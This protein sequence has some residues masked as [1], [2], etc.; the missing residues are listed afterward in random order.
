MFYAAGAIIMSYVIPRVESRFM[1]QFMTTISVPSAVAYYSSVATGMLAL[2]GVIFSLLFVMV[3]FSATAYSPR[4]VLWIASDRSISH[5][6][7]V[8][9][10][11]FIF[12]LAALVWVDRDHSGTVGQLSAACVVLLL[13]ASIAVLGYLVQR[14][15][16]LRISNILRLV[17][18][19]GRKEIMDL[20]PRLTEESSKAGDAAQPPPASAQQP[21]VTQTISYSGNPRAVETIDAQRLISL[22]RRAQAVIEVM[23]AVGDM[24]FDGMP[25]LNVRG[26]GK[27]ISERRLRKSIHLHTERTFAQDP[28]YVLRILVDIAIRAL[29]P[30]VN[31]PTTAV[32]ALDQIE[33][34]LHLLARRDLDIGRGRDKDDVLRLTMPVPSWDD[35]LSLACDEILIYGSTSPQVVRRMRAMLRELMEAV[36]PGRRPAVERQIAALDR[37]IDR[38]FADDDHR[39][40]ARKEDRQGLGLS[41]RR[42]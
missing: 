29:S 30:A 4:I 7:G 42:P 31:D 41:R 26:A 13:L 37:S 5:S 19:S 15:G 20:Y 38:S 1:S 35:Y 18:E 23:T 22:A 39:T 12:S 9:T 32:Q 16:I 6:L 27:K 17:G 14:I 34:L 8:F 25:L 40:E 11:T 3:T 21:P 28:K 33:D 36:S 2:T 10:S 24:V